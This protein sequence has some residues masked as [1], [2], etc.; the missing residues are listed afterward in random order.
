[1]PAVGTAGGILVGVRDN[2][3]EVVSWDIHKYSIT[4]F[5]KNRSNASVWRFIYVYGS[6]YDEFKLDFINE[7]HNVF[8]GVGWAYPY[9]GRF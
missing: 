4:C 5:L 1:M 2:L 3:F 8:S 9:W 6:T 7:L